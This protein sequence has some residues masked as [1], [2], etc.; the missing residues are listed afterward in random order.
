MEQ[1]IENGE[2]VS[3]YTVQDFVRTTRPDGYGY[4]YLDD[5]EIARFE[6]VLCDNCNAHITQ[7]VDDD[8]KQVVFCLL[9]RAL[10]TQCFERWCSS[11]C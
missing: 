6:E 10:C 2:L 4:I 8:Q 1:T 5:E 7:P 11:R 9:D 3:A